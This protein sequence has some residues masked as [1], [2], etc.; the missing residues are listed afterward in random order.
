MDIPVFTYSSLPSTND[1]ALELYE[2]G[3]TPPFIVLAVRQTRGRGRG[4]HTWFSPEGGLWFSVALG[5][6]PAEHLSGLGLWT[7]Y[8]TVKT[9]RGLTDL[10]ILLKLPNDIV[11]YGK[12]LGGILIEIRRNCA[13]AGI[14][15][16]TNV[17]TFPAPLSE[18]AISLLQV[19]GNR[20][21][22]ESIYPGIAMRLWEFVHSP[23][24]HQTW[25]PNV[26]AWL[27]GKGQRVAVT[28]SNR[29][30]QGVL[31]GVT[32]DFHMV[33]TGTEGEQA[34]S[35]AFLRDFEIVNGE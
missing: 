27:F 22:H 7:A 29:R 32:P 30:V 34:L 25:L 8:V 12:K 1:T 31:K 33:L 6:V 9:L 23:P 11:L 10:P 21:T 16:N 24:S 3:Q 35:L 28:C 19:L 5:P 15:L 2:Q 4:A 13:I 14:G 18:T 26:N 17:S 20:I